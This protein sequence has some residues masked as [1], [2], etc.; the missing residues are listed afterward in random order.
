VTNKM[1][2]HYDDM[3]KQDKST[4]CF[5]SVS[6]TRGRVPRSWNKREPPRIKRRCCNAP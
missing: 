1:L 4:R 2:R 5:V 3:M 6:C